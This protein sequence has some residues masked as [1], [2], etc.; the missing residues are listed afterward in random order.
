MCFLNYLFLFSI[1]SL[2]IF[3]LNNENINDEW[4]VFFDGNLESVKKYAKSNDLILIGKVRFELI[5]LY[6]IKK[7]KN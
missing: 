4:V 5:L 2:T 6:K 3:G 1:F 7:L